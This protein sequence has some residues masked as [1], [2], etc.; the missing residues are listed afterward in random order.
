MEQRADVWLQDLWA[1]RETAEFA[2]PP[3]ARALTPGDVVTLEA[4][5]RERTLEL[6]EIVDTEQRRISA[7]AIDVDVFTTPSGM[8]RRPP[9]VMPSPLGPVQVALLELPMLPDDDP[10]VLAH[11]AVFADPW[12]GPVAIWRS[13]DDGAS[14][15]QFAI[16]MAPAV[17][18]E[19]LDGLPAGPT[20]RWD[21]VSHA[22]VTLYGGALASASD[23][24]VLSG[25]NAGAVQRPD[26]PWEILQFA[27]AVLTADRTYELSRLLRGELGSEA[28][29][30]APLAAGAPFVL[31]DPHLT[32]IAQGVETIGRRM[33]FRVVAANRD[34]GDASAVEI[35]LRPGALAFQP[36]APV[37]LKARRET[38]GVRFSWRTRKRG[39]AGVTFAARPDLGEA[40]ASYELEI[41]SGPSVM[42]TL[43]AATPSTLYAASDETLDFGTAQSSFAVRLYQMS[44]AVGRGL[45]ATATLTP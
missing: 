13:L 43:F 35:E 11:L 7:R 1:G 39:L 4:N 32:P 18:G 33:R 30:G 10:P 42:R 25:S 38:G 37:H 34:H 8:P 21:K 31:L 26:G 12:P 44:A 17:M 40:A 45:P 16:V 41:L 6:R 3:S 27:N 9:P 22:R 23:L 5:D 19:T 29:I 2:L 20:S 28:A 36:L 14:Y 24:R 15:Q